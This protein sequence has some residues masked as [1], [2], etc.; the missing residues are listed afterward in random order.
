MRIYI[1]SVP[2]PAPA[3]S[4]ES[5]SAS[6][7]TAA[8][9]TRLQAGIRKLNVYTDGTIRYANLVAGEV[10]SDLSVAMADPRW[11]EAMDSEFSA[12]IRN[13]TWHL[14]PPSKDRNLIDFKW[15][16]K[17]KR[18]TDGSIDRYKA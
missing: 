5:I 17:I 7:P 15:V 1:A 4:T 12:L 14:V 2:A 8:P 13:K 6:E 3:V 11:K 18:K 10:P 9:R 16:F